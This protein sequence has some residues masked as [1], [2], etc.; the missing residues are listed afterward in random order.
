M[1]KQATSFFGRLP[2]EEEKSLVRDIVKDVGEI[3]TRIFIPLVVVDKDA[4]VE[5]ARDIKRKLEE[6]GI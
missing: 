3:Y 5:K 4:V 1:Q 6:L 2:Y